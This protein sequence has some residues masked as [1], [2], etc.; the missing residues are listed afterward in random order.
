[1]RLYVGRGHTKHADLFFFYPI[2]ADSRRL[3]WAET[4]IF[5]YDD[6]RIGPAPDEPL[7]KEERRKL[8]LLLS[9]TYTHALIVDENSR[10]RCA[11]KIPFTKS[12]REEFSKLSE[13][14]T[15]YE[16]KGI[17]LVQAK[18]ALDTYLG[19]VK[20]PFLEQ[21]FEL[22]LREEGPQQ[23]CASSRVRSDGIMT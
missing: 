15:E 3:W 18:S 8:S 21:Q 9:Q 12:Q 17:S 5:P 13:L 10:L 11:R 20:K 2:V 23:D 4:W 14:L 19:W 16:G 7:A 6:E 1:M 22:L